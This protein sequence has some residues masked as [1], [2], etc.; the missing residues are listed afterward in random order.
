M[1]K[2]RKMYESDAEQFCRSFLEQG[3]PP[4]MEIFRNYYAEQEKGERDVFVA[5]YEKRPVG[6]IT[7]LPHTKSG[8]FAKLGYPELTDFNVLIAYQKRGIG[9]RI[10]DEAEKAASAYGDHV[11]LAVGLHSGYGAAQRLYVKR[12]Y[13]PDGSGVWYRN[14]ILKPYTTCCNDDDLILYMSKKI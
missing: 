2:I 6:Y 14:E 3:W 7:L 5:E 9:S 4:K 12:G 13:I 10:M 1:L 11:S 8:P